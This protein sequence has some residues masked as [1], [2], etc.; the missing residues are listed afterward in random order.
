MRRS[1]TSPTDLTDWTHKK[2]A[3]LK[4]FELAVTN[5]QVACKKVGISRQTFYNWMQGDQDFSKAVSDL[6]EA[7]LDDTE[8]ELFKAIRKGN[9]AAIIFTLKTRAKGRGYVERQEISGPEGKS[10]TSIIGEGRAVEICKTF[11][12]VAK[13]RRQQNERDDLRQ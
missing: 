8:T 13:R 11:L 1:Q 12:E 4:A 7:V 10:L 2:R 5:V 3:F 6:R 9:I